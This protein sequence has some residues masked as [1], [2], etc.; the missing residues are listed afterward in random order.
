MSEINDPLDPRPHVFSFSTNLYSL[1]CVPIIHLPPTF[2]CSQPG[3]DH[4]PHTNM[5]DAAVL[6]ALQKGDALDEK[7]ALDSF[8]R[9]MT[10]A[11]CNTLKVFWIHAKDLKARDAAVQ[12]ESQHYGTAEQVADILKTILADVFLVED[13]DMGDFDQEL[14]RI[15]EDQ[16]APFTHMGDFMTA[17]TAARAREYFA[18]EDKGSDKPRDVTIDP[19]SAKAF[20]ADMWRRVCEGL[21]AWDNDDIVAFLGALPACTLMPDQRP[22]K[23]RNDRSVSIQ[24][25]SVA[26]DKFSALVKQAC[27]A[28][29]D[30][31]ISI[32]T[33]VVDEKKLPVVYQEMQQDPEDVQATA[34]HDDDGGAQPATWQLESMDK[35]HAAAEEAAAATV[36]EETA[37]EEEDHISMNLTQDT[38]D[39]DD[40][41][42]E[43]PILDDAEPAETSPV[44]PTPT[45]HI[46]SPFPYDP[47]GVAK[48]T[49]GGPV[50]R[51]AKAFASGRR[52][53]SKGTHNSDDESSE[54]EEEESKRKVNK[55]TTAAVLVRKPS[56]K[57]TPAPA[58]KRYQQEASS[59]SSSSDSDSTDTSSDSES[60]PETKKKPRRRTPPIV[61]AAPKK[62]AASAKRIA[63]AAATRRTP[64]MESVRSPVLKLNNNKK[65]SSAAAVQSPA[66]TIRSPAATI[67]SPAAAIRSPAVIRS[68]AAVSS[69]K[70][71]LVHE[72]NE[73]QAVV[74]ARLVESL[75]QAD[76]VTLASGEEVMAIDIDGNDTEDISNL[77]IV[78]E[79]TT[80]EPPPLHR[81]RHKTSQTPLVPSVL[82]DTDQEDEEGDEK[83]DDF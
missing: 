12:P 81:E 45:I 51:Y 18:N 20:F 70:A 38:E 31:V 27:L 64:T 59:S 3:G 40:D 77:Q 15:E 5:D 71:A 75:G 43:P 28:S 48:K 33:L 72:Q 52:R 44:P 4:A 39:D 53:R 61:A 30:A 55:R 56:A 29:C 83:G 69:P 17:L 16:K 24:Q 21:C 13:A 67:R 66:A 34:E 50:R 76:I 26:Y 9:F 60:S 49:A 65:P 37:A 36:G 19:A 35:S 62:T 82:Y 79:H 22:P 2:H 57:K 14:V 41:D 6:Q 78:E 8:C 25:H 73:Q 80:T 63:A 32:S 10:A 42:E 7:T 46:Q 68:P 74:T 54:E 23:R 47:E 11:L 58:R 1:F